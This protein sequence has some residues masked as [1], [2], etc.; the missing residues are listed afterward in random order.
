VKLNLFTYYRNIN[1]T[2]SRYNPIRLL[3]YVIML[4]RIDGAR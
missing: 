4:S 1:G 3:T 2:F